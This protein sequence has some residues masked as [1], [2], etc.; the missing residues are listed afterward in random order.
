MG[1]SGLSYYVRG[2]ASNAPDCKADGDLD[3]RFGRGEATRVGV[4]R[5]GVGEAKQTAIA[6]TRR[7]LD[8]DACEPVIVS[9]TQAGTKGMEL[10]WNSDDKGRAA[11]EL[12]V[13]VTEEADG[14]RADGGRDV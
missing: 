7:K 3:E 8:K 14:E 9:K 13:D 11:R 4:G 12:A 5:V 10:T 1:V 2:T 6:E